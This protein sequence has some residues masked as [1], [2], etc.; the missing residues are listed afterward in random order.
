MYLEDFY[1]SLCLLGLRCH[2]DDACR[3]NPCH[4]GA[5]CETSPLDGK[6][7]CSCPPGWT[8]EDCTT[9]P[10]ECLDGEL[11][12]ISNFKKCGKGD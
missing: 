7:L 9:D 2:L 11:N 3:S 1:V 5:L 8:G 6:Y 4:A 10:N 12:F